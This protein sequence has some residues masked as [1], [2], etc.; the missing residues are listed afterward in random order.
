MNSTLPSTAM[1]PAS[2]SAHP[3]QCPCETCI[4]FTADFIATTNQ[5]SHQN[6]HQLSRVFANYPPASRALIS[7]FSTYTNM[8]REAAAIITGLILEPAFAQ[9]TDQRVLERRVIE[10]STDNKQEKGA[11]EERLYELQKTAARQ[12]EAIK[13]QDLV[14]DAF[15]GRYAHL[16]A[17][18]SAMNV[19][20]EASEREREQTRTLVNDIGMKLTR[21]MQRIM[22]DG[23]LSGMRVGAAIKEEVVDLARVVKDLQNDVRAIKEE[24]KAFAGSDQHFD[25][26]IQTPALVQPRK[27]SFGELI[28]FAM[29]MIALGFFVGSIREP[30][31]K[32][33]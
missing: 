31:R 19:R 4:T 14:N 2:T 8:S 33:Y 7:A 26:Q 30:V 13:T 6:A 18:F 27:C 9:K 12:E 5:A 1:L 25:D 23:D 15:N 20:V 17:L 10:Q 21:F 24:R 29:C 22:E 32:G 3:P 28:L 11:I 16:T